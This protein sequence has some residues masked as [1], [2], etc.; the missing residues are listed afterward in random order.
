MLWISFLN[1]DPDE[2]SVVGGTCGVLEPKRDPD[3]GFPEGVEDLLRSLNGRLY[4]YWGAE[5][6]V[7]GGRE[8]KPEGVAASFLVFLLGDGKS[9]DNC[10][11]TPQFSGIW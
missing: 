8:P 9:G 7:D 4:L 10:P 6:I 3:R 2:D 11:N 1:K 5:E